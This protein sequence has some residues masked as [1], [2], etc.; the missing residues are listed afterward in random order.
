MARRCH[1]A[2]LIEPE[3]LAT[4][5]AL[6]LCVGSD[7]SFVMATQRLQRGDARTP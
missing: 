5:T 3:L 4:M 1:A 6:L 7:G 2:T